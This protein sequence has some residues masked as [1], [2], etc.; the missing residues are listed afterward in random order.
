MDPSMT[1]NIGPNLVTPWLGLSLK[2]PVVAS[3][4]PLCQTVTGVAQLAKA[5]AAA[6]I[7]PSLFEEQLHHDAAAFEFLSSAG[8][9][10]SAESSS[11]FPSFPEFDRGPTDYLKL[12]RDARAAI[13]VP[14][15]ASLNG[16]TDSGWTD[17]AREIEKAGAD[18]LELNVYG[19][20]VDEDQNA[21]MVEDRY[22]SIV[23]QV[24]QSIRIPVSVKM[25]PYFSSPMEM[26]DR[27]IE[28]GAS[29]LVLFNRFYQPDFDLEKME[30]VPS[31]QL[32][33]PSE[34][35]LPL[36]WLSVLFGRTSGSLAASTGVETSS[37]V[38]KYLLA[39]ADVVMTTSAL[40]RHGP[41]HLRTLT[42]GLTQW[43]TQRGYESVGQMRGAMSLRNARNPSAFVRANYMKTLASYQHPFV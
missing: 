11:Y 23:K 43:M 36:L 38:I 25:N 31:L 18:A 1:R 4:S 2:H 27:L 19:L 41:E 24:T 3:A 21:R 17:Y 32:S 29:G 5:G 34:I 9:D 10:S 7:L 33:S 6:V 8:C 35:R 16:T 13:D 12:I 37:E 40:L 28:A 39:G 26:A 42:D 14:L 30:V 20:P 15:I 22:V